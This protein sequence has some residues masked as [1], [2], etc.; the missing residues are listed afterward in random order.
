ML[1]AETVLFGT[2][3]L[4]YLF[5]RA[6]HPGSGLPGRADVLLPVVN[7]AVL[8]ASAGTA[9]AAVR[10][11]RQGRLNVL[12]RDLLVTLVLGLSFVAGQV[13][14]F[15]RSGMKP[16]DQEFGGAFFALIGFHALHVL[17]GVIFLAINVVRAVLG[18]FDRRRSIPVE[19][20]AWFWYYVTGVWMVLFVALYV[21]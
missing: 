9:A 7:T 13:I 20:G 10:A 4:A 6:N 2:L 19:M 18:D 17:A 8:L 11:V 3:L 21:V 16:D 14:E 5:L 15:S 12:T 1:G